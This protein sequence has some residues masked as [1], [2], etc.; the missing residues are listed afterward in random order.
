[1]PQHAQLRID[2]GLAIYFYDPPQ[3]WPRGTNEDTKGLLRQYVPK[4]TDLS[5]R[6]PTTWPPSPLPP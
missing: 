6:V 1:M 5:K 2:T 4:G 3:P